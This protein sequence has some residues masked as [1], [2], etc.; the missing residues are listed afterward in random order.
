MDLA[1]GKRVCMRRPAEVRLASL[2]RGIT[3][4]ALAAQAVGWVGITEFDLLGSDG[5]PSKRLDFAPELWAVIV[6]DRAAWASKC[7]DAL[8]DLVNTHLAST[9]AVEKN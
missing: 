2:G 1:P 3:V 5:D 8:L 7:A 4:E 9:E 6:E